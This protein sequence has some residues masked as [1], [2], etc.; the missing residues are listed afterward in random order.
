MSTLTCIVHYTDQDPVKYSKIK[1]ISAVNEQRIKAAKLEREQLVDSSNRHLEQCRSIPEIIDYQKHG[2]HME[3]CYKKFTLI[4]AK[5]AK[6]SIPKPVQ[7]LSNSCTPASDSEKTN[8]Y[9]NICNYCKKYQLKQ[10]QKI[11]F[12]KTITTSDA[13]ATIKA[14]AKQNNPDLYY[15]IKDHDLIAREFKYHKKCY[16]DINRG[17]TFKARID[18]SE[19]AEPASC[20]YPHTHNY[21]DLDAVKR[22]I[23][24]NLD[25][26]PGY[27]NK[28]IS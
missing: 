11:Q 1:Q 28:N 23:E 8:V 25:G 13:V 18:S 10:K 15:E 27:I 17:F 9:P 3:P 4:L 19:K 24:Q 5:K 6:Q 22:C 2:I 14:A 21:H 26:E 7:R 20:S 12:P 16:N